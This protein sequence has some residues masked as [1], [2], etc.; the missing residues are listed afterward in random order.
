MTKEKIY[1]GKSIAEIRKF[2][3]KGQLKKLINEI[4]ASGEYLDKEIKELGI[5]LEELKQKDKK[6]IKKLQET[7]SVETDEIKPPCV[8]D[9]ME[10]TDDSAWRERAEEAQKFLETTLYDMRQ[11]IKEGRSFKRG[12]WLDLATVINSVQ[13]VLDKDRIYHDQMYRA[14][15]TGFIDEFAM[16][17]AE[18]EERAKLTKEY[19]NYKNSVLQRERLDELVNICK[20]QDSKEI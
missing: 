8:D 13:E 6:F 12:F 16:S 10:G 7:F 2:Y 20:K 5:Y 11:G 15:M 4:Q 9:L 19:T 14:K 3:F 1:C 18:S 17:R